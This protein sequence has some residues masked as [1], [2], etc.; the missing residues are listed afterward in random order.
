MTMEDHLEETS[1]RRGALRGGDITAL[2]KA[3]RGSP[4]N[5]SDPTARADSTNMS[6]VSWIF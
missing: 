6:G 2:I 4:I 3:Y 1:G 5:H